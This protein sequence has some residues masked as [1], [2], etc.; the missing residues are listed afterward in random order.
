[1]LG[2]IPTNNPE[3]GLIADDDRKFIIGTIDPE[4]LAAHNAKSYYLVTDWLETNDDDET[5]LVRKIYP[6]GKIELLHIAKVMVDDE[7]KSKKSLINEEKFQEYMSQNPGLPHVE[8]TRYEFTFIQNGIT[9]KAKYDEFANKTLRILEI[10]AD[11]ADK[12]ASFDPASFD[13]P[14][15]EVSDDDNYRGYR[16]ASVLQS[17]Q[18]NADTKH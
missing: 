7:R 2:E 17:L 10:D 15:L 3:K 1:M 14:L 6:D 9:F 16:V 13:Y 5:K 11:D 12:R 4:F 18:E 8:K